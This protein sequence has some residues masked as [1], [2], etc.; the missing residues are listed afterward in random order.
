MLESNGGGRGI[1]T[2]G[3]VS[4]TVVF[5]T[6]RFNRSRIPPRSFYR[7][8]GILLQSPFSPGIWVFPSTLSHTGNCEL[9]AKQVSLCKWWSF[10]T[11]SDGKNGW[12]M[13]SE[14]CKLWDVDEGRKRVFRIAASILAARKLSQ[15]E[16]RAGS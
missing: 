1:R 9:F 15:Y 10:L 3:T 14:R 13:D 5:K 8:A 11:N 16:G 12:R 7:L 2:P 6:T 4:R